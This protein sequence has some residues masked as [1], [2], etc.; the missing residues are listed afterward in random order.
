MVVKAKKGDGYYIR[1]EFKKLNCAKYENERDNIRC[2][3]SWFAK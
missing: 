1:C 2:V 3:G